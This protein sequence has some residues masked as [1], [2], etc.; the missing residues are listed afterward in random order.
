MI[1]FDNAASTWPKPPEVS[2]A[3]LTNIEQYAAN[4][5]RGG[6][7]LS[8][9]AGDVVQMTRKSLASLFS[10]SDPKNLIFFANATQ[11]LNQAIKGYLQPG[12]HV[13]TT[14]IEHNS[15]RRPLAFLEKEKN[16]EVSYVSPRPGWKFEVDDFRKEIRSQTRLIVVSHGS[17]VTGVILPIDEIGALAREK[18]IVFLVD[19]SQTA[20]VIDIKVN[21][22]GI[23]MLAF[24]GHKGLYGPQGTGGLYISPDIELTPIFH[25]GTG[26]QSEMVEQPP[27]RPDRFESGTLNTVGIA[28]LGAGVEFVK[29]TGIKTIR[30]QEKK[31]TNHLIDA[32]LSMEGITVIGPDQGQE[33][34]GVVSFTMD[35]ID[36]SEVAMILDQHYQIA[37]RAGFHCSP[38]AHET[39]GTI[40]SGGAVRISFGYF[41]TKNEVDT[42]IDAIKEIHESMTGF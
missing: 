35:H 30:D 38:L 24:P 9:K 31:L 27:N 17:N 10:I 1:Y 6:H 25:G 28:G 39:A 5:G 42:L 13:I 34:L 8:K 32:L 14:T 40:H 16:I 23:D 21:E 37:V 26:S 12:D 33:R 36:S 18:G 2:R 29:K 19:A 4:P 22:A 15:V 11:A 7:Q 3:M 41:N 20:G